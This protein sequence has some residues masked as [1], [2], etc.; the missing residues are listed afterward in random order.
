MGFGIPLR[1]HHVAIVVNVPANS[2]DLLEYDTGTGMDTA[3]GNKNK[4]V[5]SVSHK[6]S[7][8]LLGKGGFGRRVQVFKY[9]VIRH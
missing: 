9:E 2:E 1:G 3:R 4:H 8:C 7:R 5:R 6:P